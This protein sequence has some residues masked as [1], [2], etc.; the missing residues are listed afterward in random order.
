MYQTLEIQ[1][2]STYGP[3]NESK[4]KQKVTLK[5]DWKIH[6]PR[7]TTISYGQYYFTYVNVVNIRVHL[8]RLMVFFFFFNRK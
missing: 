4:C 6:Q 8:F 5:H 1:I 3:P 7:N 2:R